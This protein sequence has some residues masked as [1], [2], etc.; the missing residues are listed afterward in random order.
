MADVIQGDMIQ[1]A[2]REFWRPP[3][4]AGLAQELVPA[5]LG[6]TLAEAC[7]GCGSEFLTGAR[8][9][10]TCG[11]GRAGLAQQMAAVGIEA[12]GFAG[13]S[14]AWASV[15]GRVGVAWRAIRFPAWMRY[16][17]FHEI[18][19]W[20]GLPTAAL[21]SFL[22]G[23]GCVTGALG[24]TFFYRASNFAEFQAIQLWRIEWLLGATAAFVAGILLKKPSDRE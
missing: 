20:V 7:G 5:A 18:K 17:H 8:F 11:G 14:L 12:D 9:C 22:V 6:V 4:A 13:S 16:L 23:L 10:H 21:V 19:S 2:E 24:V 1:G 15:A 3:N